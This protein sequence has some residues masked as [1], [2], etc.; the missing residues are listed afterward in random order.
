[1]DRFM[2]SVKDITYAIATSPVTFL[3][4]ET[5]YIKDPSYKDLKFHCAVTKQGREVCRWGPD[6]LKKLLEYLDTCK[7]IVGHNAISFDIPALEAMGNWK[8]H[9]PV[10]DT[11]V[12]ARVC[13]PDPA[14]CNFNP[15]FGHSL[16][17]WGTRL[18]CEKAESP[19]FSEYSPE[20]LEY[21]VQ[22]VTV[23]ETLYY[24]LLGQSVPFEVV[25]V[26]HLF[27]KICADQVRTGVLFDQKA[28]Q[29]LHVQLIKRKRELSE[30]F[31]DILLCIPGKIFVPTR[32]DKRLGY[33][34]GR[35]CTKVSIMEFN[36][37]SRAHVQ[38]YLTRKYGWVPK[39]FTPAGEVK[40]DQEVLSKLPYPEAS[41]FEE[42]YGVDKILGFLVDGTEG[43]T[44]LSAV[45]TEDSRIHGQ[46][47]TN[48]AVTG[49]PIYFKPAINQVPSCSSPYGKQ[50]R[51]LFTVPPGKKLVGVDADALE[52]RML[53]HYLHH[54]DSGEYA[55]AV[56]KGDKSAGTD[57]HTK[58]QKAIGLSSRD[59][60]K[61]WFYAFIYGAGAYKLGGIVDPTLSE[62]KAKRLGGKLRGNFLRNTPAIAR[63]QE[64]V[65]KTVTAKGV[66]RGIDGR[67]L[68]IR[69]QHSALNTLLQNAGIVAMKVAK[70]ILF[71]ELAADEYA[72]GI[73][74]PV[75]DIVDEWQFECDPAFAEELGKRACEAIRL[76]GEYLKCN[77]PLKGNADIGINWASTH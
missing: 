69:S 54:W 23:L 36:P 17:A 37:T 5:T 29:E 51:S 64:A 21:C 10:L 6:E 66:L 49:R 3:D 72:A 70:V 31:K 33:T 45:R 44:W 38:K 7:V 61:R 57:A 1:M 24:F 42:L 15:P 63:L 65:A 53:A 4:I 34:A 47:N 58:N 56:D 74:K 35:P 71:T 12:W 30:Q 52:M 48:G 20:M 11:L 73:F 76:A 75:L 18:N 39:D 25:G 13:F 50:C 40:V 14:L 67:T 19:E 43:N 16:A 28:A 77:C 26:E 68:H 60:A 8:C 41:V 62:D 55:T 27:A 9:A 22:D 2:Q 59:V 32:N 46:M